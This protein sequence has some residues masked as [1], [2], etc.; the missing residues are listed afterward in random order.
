MSIVEFDGP[1]SW[2]LGASETGESTKCPW[3]GVVERFTPTLL[4]HRHHPQAFVSLPSFARI[5]KPRWWPV[6]L[7]DRHLRSHGKIRDG[8]QS[9]TIRAGLAGVKVI[10]ESD[11]SQ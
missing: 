10:L 9:S 4:T 7:N 2:S 3:V 5:K 6:E 11:C 8:E 1:L